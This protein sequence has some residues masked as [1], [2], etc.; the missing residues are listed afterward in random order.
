MGHHVHGH[1][2]LGPTTLT[3]LAQSHAMEDEL[4]ERCGDT[5]VQHLRTLLTDFIEPHGGEL[6]A[7][8]SRAPDKPA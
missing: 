8:R 1:P 7:Q 4:R 5:R 2:V 3:A 6:A